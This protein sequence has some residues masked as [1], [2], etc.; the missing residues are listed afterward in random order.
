MATRCI[1]RVEGADYAAIYKHYDGYPEATLPWLEEFNQD[2][3][4]IRGV[5]PAYKLA[6][7]LRASAFRYEEYKLGG[8]FRKMKNPDVPVGASYDD[9][10]YL[11]TTDERTYTGWGVIGADWSMGEEFIYIL[12]DD[13][14]V[15]VEDLYAGRD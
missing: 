12:K 14:T 11:I 10:D 7:I 4:K 15:E 6:Q 2:F 8:E 5:D 3:A 1:I 9:P 13:G